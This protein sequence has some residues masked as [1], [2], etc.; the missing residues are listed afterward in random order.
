MRKIATMIFTTLLLVSC[1]DVARQKASEERALREEAERTA[2]RI[3]R[4]NLKLAE[5]L[6]YF[7]DKRTG[8]CFLGY[9]ENRITEISE[10]SITN[11]PCTEEVKKLLVNP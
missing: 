2:G 6:V 8:L 5:Y 3:R 4:I 1:D 7:Q 10:D 11:V 9:N